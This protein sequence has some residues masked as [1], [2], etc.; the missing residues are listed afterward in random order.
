MLIAAILCFGGQGQFVPTLLRVAG[1][2]VVIV[3]GYYLILILGVVGAGLYIHSFHGD[4]WG[5]LGSIG[6]G[7]LSVPGPLSNQARAQAP[8]DDSVH[9]GFFGGLLRL[10]ALL[11]FVFWLINRRKGKR[12]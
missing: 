6:L 11:G 4:L 7:P 3:V 10:V 2:F 8:A 12:T 1:V 5:L 9:P